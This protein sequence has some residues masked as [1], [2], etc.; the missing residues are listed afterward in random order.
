MQSSVI[1]QLEV[2]DNKTSSKI[3]LAKEEDIKDHRHWDNWKQNSK[4]LKRF[5]A[6]TDIDQPRIHRRSELKC[7]LYK[8]ASADFLYMNFLNH[9]LSLSDIKGKTL[10]CFGQCYA[11]I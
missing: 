9:D 4:K 7:Q 6:A 1:S 3:K 8:S 5:E 10:L 2:N 11:F